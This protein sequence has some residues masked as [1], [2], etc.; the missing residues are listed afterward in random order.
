MQ[1]T[2]NELSHAF[3]SLQLGSKRVFAILSGAY[4]HKLIRGRSRR[5]C[6]TQQSGLGCMSKC[7]WFLTPSNYRKD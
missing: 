5:L 2:Q 7:S 4:S 1:E 3:Q 6:P